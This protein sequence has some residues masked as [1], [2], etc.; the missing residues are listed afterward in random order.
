[1]LS[2][3]AGNAIKARR[4]AL[5]LSQEALGDACHPK[6]LAR[7]ES[8]S[9]NPTLSTLE[10]VSRKLHCRVVDLLQAEPTPTPLVTPPLTKRERRILE[11]TQNLGSKEI[12]LLLQLAEYLH[13]KGS[14]P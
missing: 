2:K 8:G 5:G 14:K 9:A 1:M 7:I 3:V 10:Q 4:K 6:V 13:G 12:R 11:A